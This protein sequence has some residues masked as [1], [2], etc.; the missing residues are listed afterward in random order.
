M[1]RVPIPPELQI[2]YLVVDAVVIVVLGFFSKQE[3]VHRTDHT[4]PATCRVVQYLIEL[5]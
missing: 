4:V 5:N 1:S 3:M 2:D